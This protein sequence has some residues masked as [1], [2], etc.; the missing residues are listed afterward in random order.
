MSSP[1]WE[2][3]IEKQY[4]IENEFVTIHCQ[5]EDMETQLICT[6]TWGP[7]CNFGT[8]YKGITVSTQ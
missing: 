8:L 5:L 1:L 3:Q 7:L 4:D 2:P 6:G